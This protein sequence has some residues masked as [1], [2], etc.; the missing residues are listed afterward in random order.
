MKRIPG[1]KSVRIGNRLVSLP[2]WQVRDLL[3]QI[4]P[5]RRKAK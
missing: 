1:V 2:D 3:K 4:T 5:K